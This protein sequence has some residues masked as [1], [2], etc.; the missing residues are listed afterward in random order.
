[1]KTKIDKQVEAAIKKSEI[2]FKGS[3]LIDKY[4]DALKKFEE[5]VDK[6]VAKKR[7]NNLISI[8]DLHL[9]KSLF[10]S[11]LSDETDLITTNL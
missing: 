4:E 10:N 9:H 5:L 11:S 7:G 6:G 8:T 2:K 3:E 1:M